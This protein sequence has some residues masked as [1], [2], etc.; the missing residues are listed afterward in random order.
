M[1]IKIITDSLSDIPLNLIKEYDIEVVPLTVIFEDGEYKDGLDLSNEEFYE[2]LKNS[3]SVPKTSQITPLEF[4]KIFKKYLDENKKILYIAGSSKATG[5]YQSSLLAKDLLDSDDI[6]TFDTMALSFGCG[7]LVVE[8]ARMAKKGKNIDE[9]LNELQHMR[10]KVDH[11]FTVDTLEY[12]QKGGRISSTKAAIGRI[13]SIKP[14]LTV[15]EGLVSQLD[16]VRGKR[17]VVSKMIELAKKRGHNLSNQVIVI[18]HGANEE[19]ALKLKEAVDKEIN[20]KD[21]IIG[22]IGSAIGTHAGPGT[23]AIFYLR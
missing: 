1:N 11:I 3:E 7:M 23:V 9:I 13:L 21:I 20:P 4:E 18:S 10:E 6:Y 16:Q 19:L 2:K 22:N 8:A 12:L 14:I 15:E 17:K 5:T